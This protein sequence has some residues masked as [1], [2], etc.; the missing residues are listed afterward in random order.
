MS[1]I[2]FPFPLHNIA[3]DTG[4]FDAD[5][6]QSPALLHRLPLAAP[7]PRVVLDPSIQKRD[8]I[9]LTR[10]LLLTDNRPPTLF[11]RSS[12]LVRTVVRDRQILQEQMTGDLMLSH[13]LERIDWVRESNQGDTA[14]IPPRE[15]VNDLLV[16]PDQRLPFLLGV[17]NVPVLL[18]S[19]RLL[20]TPGYDSE[21][22]ILFS[23]EEGVSYK[24]PQ[25]PASQDVVDASNLL[26]DD[27]LGG[28]P[29]CQNSHRALSGA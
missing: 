11:R 25:R 13:L 27:L 3:P 8:I 1:I 23:P 10:D 15:V 12:T 4:E 28:F 17:T 29:L 18:P 22:G 2:Q 9:S 26:F 6:T 7:R 5:D 14:A 21:S 16:N 19:G 24:V 20:F